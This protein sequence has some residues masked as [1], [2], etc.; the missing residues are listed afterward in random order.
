MPRVLVADNLEAAGLDLLR[1]AGIELDERTGLKDA[2]LREALQAAD[3]VI[4][5]SQ[6]A[7]SPRPS[8]KIPASCASS[9]APASAWT[10]STSPPPP[11]AAF[12]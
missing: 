7:A 10:P 9:S 6:H 5:R 2:A 11:A 8:W 12:S 4:V 1:Q 3:G